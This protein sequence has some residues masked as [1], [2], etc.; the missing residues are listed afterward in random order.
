MAQRNHYASMVGGIAERGQKTQDEDDGGGGKHHAMPARPQKQLTH[1]RGAMRWWRTAKGCGWVKHAW[2]RP[3]SG[4]Y[5]WL[6]R[7]RMRRNVTNGAGHCDSRPDIS[8]LPTVHFLASTDRTRRRTR[9]PPPA[10]VTICAAQ[11]G[12]PHP[13]PHRPLITISASMA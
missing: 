9:R 8:S 11:G 12:L 6:N 3:L 4:I 2:P 5:T 1:A 13:G 10:R 7:I